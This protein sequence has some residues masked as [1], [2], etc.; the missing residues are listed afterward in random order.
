MGDPDVGEQGM[1]VTLGCTKGGPGGELMNVSAEG[2]SMR[3]AFCVCLLATD[4]LSIDDRFCR[5]A[6]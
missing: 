2:R 3:C 5:T 6:R 4:Q 1:T